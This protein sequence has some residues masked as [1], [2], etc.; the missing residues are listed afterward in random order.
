M[1]NVFL[2]VKRIGRLYLKETLVSYDHP[3]IFV[4]EDDYDSLYLF[5]EINDDDDEIEW[6]VVKITRQ[7]YFD[8]LSSK[9][10]LVH[11]FRREQ[12]TP[13]LLI[14]YYYEDEH[15]EMYESFNLQCKEILEL[16]ETYLSDFENIKTDEL[17]LGIQG[18]SSILE[19][20]LYPGMAIDSINIDTQNKLCKNVKNIVKNM[21]ENSRYLDVRV[22]QSKVASYSIPLVVTS[23]CAKTIS[24]VDV[25]KDLA[26]LIYKTDLSKVKEANR[27][28]IFTSLKK[29]Y[30]SIQSTKAD[31]VIG[32]IKSGTQ[33]K[34][35][36][37]IYTTECDNK[38]KSIESALAAI[39]SAVDNSLEEIVMGELTAFNIKDG[40]FKFRVG[41]EKEPHG[42]IVS[43]LKEKNY[44]VG[45]DTKY[46]AKI[47]KKGES[48][49]LVSLEEQ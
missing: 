12:S 49:L 40:T 13:F 24:A 39:N 32:Y 11:E 1:S 34:I 20:E 38:R 37:T 6:Q 27:H 9:I 17:D 19:L 42:K 33:E 22:G 4:C 5:H 31:F 21:G 26:E 29:I 45:K 36:N 7:T 46:K 15:T 41:S 25:T 10:S 47:R 48:Y 35:Y 18:D 8:I 16:K 28:Q 3:L 43:E 2:N 23:S 30:E 14:K 44:T